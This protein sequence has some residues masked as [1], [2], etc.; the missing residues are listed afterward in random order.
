MA[1]SA[2]EGCNWP[3]G[4]MFEFKAPGMRRLAALRPAAVSKRI[5][6][7]RRPGPWHWRQYV[8]KKGLTCESKS[9]L[10]ATTVGWGA[11]AGA[12]GAVSLVAG[13]A[14]PPEA[15]LS[16]ILAAKVGAEAIGAGA[17]AA[18]AEAVLGLVAQAPRA[19]A[20]VPIKSAEGEKGSFIGMG[21][22]G[23]AI[24]RNITRELGLMKSK[25]STL[26]ELPDAGLAA[27]TMPFSLRLDP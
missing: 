19:S 24:N 7:A 25:K 2:S 6:L 11:A 27:I 22:D 8:E 17:A 20:K 14:A 26:A 12:A 23:M 5:P 10:A 18:G 3:S 4:G 9:I 15:E 1:R 21:L 16:G 13:F